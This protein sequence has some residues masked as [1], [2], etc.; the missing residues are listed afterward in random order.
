[1]P[2]FFGDCRTHQF[3]MLSIDTIRSNNKLAGIF[4]ASSDVPP[5]SDSQQVQ[6]NQNVTVFKRFSS[7]KLGELSSIK[8]IF[9]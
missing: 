3:L 1:M 4:E 9:C 7:L 8:Q 5:K 6:V 2:P